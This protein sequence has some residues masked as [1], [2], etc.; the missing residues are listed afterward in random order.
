MVVEKWLEIKDMNFALFA[1]TIVA[2]LI[3]IFYF[4][5]ILR[6]VSNKLLWI[7]SCILPS[8]ILVILR[9]QQE[10]DEMQ[11]NII[12][13]TLL[14]ILLFFLLLPWLFQVCIIRLFINNKRA[15][16]IARLSIE[17]IISE[18]VSSKKVMEYFVVLILPFITIG[19]KTIDTLTM[20]YVLFIL[21]AIF[22]RL[23]LFHFNLPLMLFY[24]ICEVRLSD[25]QIYYLIS[26]RNI[27]LQADSELPRE[28]ITLSDEL[29]IAI[30]HK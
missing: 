19:S 3:V 16:H 23:K 1:C 22:L 7:Y 15:D 13:I 12:N 14:I 28:I 30:L 2:I 29:K 8:I 11:Y 24:D 25:G 4:L 27:T 6:D 26:Q 10:D 21:I 18:G 5:P 17:E 20:C 9:Y